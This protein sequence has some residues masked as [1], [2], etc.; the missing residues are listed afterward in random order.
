MH[1][2]RVQKPP[3]SVWWLMC[4]YVCARFRETVEKN[5]GTGF[6]LTQ[7]VLLAHCRGVLLL[8]HLT[9]SVFPSC[10]S[11]AFAFL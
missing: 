4:V 1:A 7:M 8:G 9:H 3:V 6:D 10:I 5:T 11:G 2:A